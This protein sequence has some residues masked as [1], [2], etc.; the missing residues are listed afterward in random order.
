MTPEWSPLGGG[1]GTMLDT[2]GELTAAAQL[3]RIAI[4]EGQDLV[5]ECEAPAA[6]P[7]RPRIEGRSVYWGEMVL[8]L[9]ARPRQ[10]P[11]VRAA[12]AEG[13]GEPAV[14]GPG[15]GYAP[16][17][18]AWGDGRL[19]VAG[20]W[21]GTPPRQPAA[22]A[23]LLDASGDRLA[24]LWEDGDLAPTAAWAGAERVVLGTRTPRVHDA[25]GALVRE[26]EPGIPALRVDGNAELVLVAE[27]HRVT[28]WDAGGDAVARWTGQ[29]LDAAISPA[30]ARV[31][32]VDADGGLWTTEP[33]AEPRAVDVPGRVAG[34]ALGDARA[35][36]ALASGAGVRTARMG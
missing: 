12:L 24:L 14:A 33:G 23:V 25:S 19:V 29:W 4:W 26:L 30:G 5:L 10:V 21:R 20:G 31:A 7:G 15:G 16:S 28:V 8:D 1:H 36:I 17:A 32:L 2:A 35:V 9:D 11:G 34:V 13:T 6:N 3:G 22:R 18:Y 27:P